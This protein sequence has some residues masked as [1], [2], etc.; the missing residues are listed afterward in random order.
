MS[1]IL[2]LGMGNRLISDDAVGILIAEEVERRIDRDDV[3]VKYGEVAGFRLVD[4]MAGHQIAIIVDAIMSDRAPIG[5]SY[6]LELDELRS[7]LRTKSNHN[8][9]IA[10]AVEL[11]RGLGMVMPDIVR[12]LAVEVEDCYTLSEEVGQRALES[13]P[14]AVDMILEEIARHTAE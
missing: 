4:L 5:E 11:G 12:V 2:V 7:P 13:I 1:R 9:H 3:E 14:L 6:W 8:I 10:D